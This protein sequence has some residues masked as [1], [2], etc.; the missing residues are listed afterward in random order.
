[1]SRPV[2][3]FSTATAMT[4][5]QFLGHELVETGLVFLPHPGGDHLAGLSARLAWRTSMGR[6]CARRRSGVADARWFAPD[7]VH[8]Q[9]NAAILSCPSYFLLDATEVVRRFD[10]RLSFG[11]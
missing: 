3:S 8:A 10:D 1:M 6:R 2:A 5:K 7:L 4:T 9:N 11:Q